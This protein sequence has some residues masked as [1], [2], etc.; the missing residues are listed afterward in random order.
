MTPVRLEPA[1][2]RS[3]VKHSTTE[4]LRSLKEFSST[5]VK[6]QDFFIILDHILTLTLLG[7]FA[8]FLLSVDFFLSKSTLTKILSGIPLECQTFFFCCLLNFIKINTIKN[9]FRHTIRASNSLVSP[10]LRSNCLQWLSAD[11]ASIGRVKFT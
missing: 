8:C 3:R 1:A 11:E 2:S 9:S 6:F 5:K 4:P 10:D 7:N